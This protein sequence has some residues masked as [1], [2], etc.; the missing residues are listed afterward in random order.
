MVRA[1]IGKLVKDCAVDDKSNGRGNKQTAA[2]TT[3]GNKPTKQKRG[4]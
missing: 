2:R 1:N 4:Q 3:S